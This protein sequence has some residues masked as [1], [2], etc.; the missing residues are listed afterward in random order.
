MVTNILLGPWHSHQAEGILYCRA[1]PSGRNSCSSSPSDPPIWK[2]HTMPTRSLIT[3]QVSQANSVCSHDSTICHRSSKSMEYGISE[4]AMDPAQVYVFP[5]PPTP[6]GIH[7]DINPPTSVPYDSNIS[8]PPRTSTPKKSHQRSA[9]VPAAPGRR[10]CGTSHQHY[11]PS[12]LWARYVFFDQK[13]ARRF[14]HVHDGVRMGR[15]VTSDGPVEV[16][17]DFND[18]RETRLG[19]WNKCQSRFSELKEP[20]IGR[21]ITTDIFSV[22]NA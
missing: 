17:G 5:S 13:V 15:R 2:S 21:E 20:E 19:R 22:I 18:L 12:K 8:S 3:M 14:A 11:C 16:A 9:S 4:P 7:P 10:Y 6:N 1:A